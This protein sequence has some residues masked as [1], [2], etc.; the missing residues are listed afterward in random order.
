MG[1]EEKMHR[2]PP[3]VTLPLLAA[4]VIATTA[5]IAFPRGGAQAG[6]PLVR[7]T[8]ASQSVAA[9]ANVSVDVVV[10]GAPNFAAYEFH[11]AFDQR[12]LTYVSVTNGETFLESTGRQAF[13]LGPEPDDLEDGIVSYACGS[14]G[15]TEGPSGG[16]TLATVTFAT[17]CGATTDL[18]FVPLMDDV[19]FVEAVTLSTTLGDPIAVD[20]QEGAVTITGTPECVFA[21]IGDANCNGTVDPIDAALVLQFAAGL[22]RALECENEADVNGDGRVDAIDAAL[23]LQFVAGLLRELPP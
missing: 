3:Q 19:S 17:F 23:I 21:E 20:T 11:L 13:C 8:P 6:G 22:L 12:A 5:V 16:G 1:K 10:S 18:R 7:V 14:T 15:V 4:L 9:G 2:R